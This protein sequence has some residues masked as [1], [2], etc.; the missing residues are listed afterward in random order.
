MQIILLL[1]VQLRAPQQFQG[2]QH[3]MQWCANLMA[4]GGQKQGFGFV[5]SF[6]YL[7]CLLQ[8]RFNLGACT[9]IAEGAQQHVLAFIAGGCTT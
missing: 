8:G 9:D 1:R 2:A 6:C 5:G 3:P 7:P 4:H